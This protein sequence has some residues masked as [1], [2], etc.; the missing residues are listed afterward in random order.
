MNRRAVGLLIA[1]GRAPPTS[2]AARCSE[3]RL[4]VGV[5]MW[6]DIEKIYLVEELPAEIERL[7]RTAER[8]AASRFFAGHTPF[9]WGMVEVDSQRKLQT[10]SWLVWASIVALPAAA[11]NDPL[12]RD[13]ES[14]GLADKWVDSEER[15]NLYADPLL[16]VLFELRNYEVHFEIRTGVW[17]NFR[18]SLGYDTRP[19]AEPQ[20]KDLGDRIYFS[21]ID[22]PSLSELRNIQMRKSKVTIEMVDWF[23]RQA[24]TWPAAHLIGAARERYSA[25]VTKFPKDCGVV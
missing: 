20:E 17:K 25:Y 14:L 9:E 6:P 2:G 12:Y 18:P 11:I 23:N 21:P 8:L 7:S 5:E 22:Y 15:R 13:L 16:A 4:F 24:T 1:I 3:V 19:D 10:K